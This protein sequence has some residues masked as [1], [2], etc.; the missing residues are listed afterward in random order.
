MDN[1]LVLPPIKIDFGKVGVTGQDHD[2]YPAPAQARYDHMRMYLI[3]LLS[4]QSSPNQPTQYREGT[5]WLDISGTVPQLKINL[6]GQWVPYSNAMVLDNGLSA[7]SL[8]DWYA[9][10]SALL[11]SLAPDI[12]FSGSATGPTSSITVPGPVL[13]SLRTNSRPFVHVN[14]LLLDPRSTTIENSVIQLGQGQMRLGDRFSVMI[15]GI[16]TQNFYVPDVPAP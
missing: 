6:G 16:P 15:R 9:Q 5:P 10:S 8:T 11:A 13:G 1:R 3:A 7:I 12:T 14:G 2:N 4:Q